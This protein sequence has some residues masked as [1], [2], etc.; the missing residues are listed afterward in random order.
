MML[1]MFT[2]AVGVAGLSVL[3]MTLRAVRGLRTTVVGR[4]L[5]L[6]VAFL[7]VSASTNVAAAVYFAMRG[8]GQDAAVPLLSLSVFLALSALSLYKFA[9]T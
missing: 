1:W 7:A 5:F 4:R 9:S 6:A 2:A 3:V 8:Y